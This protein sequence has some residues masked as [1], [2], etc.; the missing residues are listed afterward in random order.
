MVEVRGSLVGLSQNQSYIVRVRSINGLGVKSS[1]S[2]SL[3]VTTGS[4]SGGG[5]GDPDP[6]PDEIPNPVSNLIVT[7]GVNT[8]LVTWANPEQN[9]KYWRVFVTDSDHSGSGPI[10]TTSASLDEYGNPIAQTNGYNFFGITKDS[11]QTISAAC[12]ET[13]GGTWG[14]IKPNTKYWVGALPISPAGIPAN[15]V[16]WASVTT[17]T[18]DN[19]FFSA[20]TISADILRASTLSADLTIAGKFTTQSG[21]SGAYVQMS[22]D[23]LLARYGSPSDTVI[24]DSSKIFEINTDSGTALFKG[25]IQGSTIDIVPND[26]VP[27]ESFH[28]DNLGRLYVGDATYAA[29]PFQVNNN[30][31]LKIQGGGTMTLGAVDGD[32]EFMRISQV[33][34]SGISYSSLGFHRGSTGNKRA[35]LTYNYQ[36]D[37]KHVIRFGSESSGTLDEM[38]LGLNVGKNVDSGRSFLRL[39]RVTDGSLPAGVEDHSVIMYAD[40]IVALAIQGQS[41]GTD[42]RFPTGNGLPG[43]NTGSPDMLPVY[44]EAAT[45]KLYRYT[46]TIRNKFH[47]VDLD[48]EVNTIEKLRGIR[49]V[50]FTYKESGVREYGFI[51]EEMDSLDRKLTVYDKDGEPGGVKYLSVLSLLVAAVQQIDDR[52]SLIERE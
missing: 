39:K 46:S 4:I 33:V 51:A 19:S 23:G 10:D 27:T 6:D 8:I 45:G 14:P 49:P 26:T 47:V 28:V 20:G 31:S 41:G 16:I 36:T 17:G 21:S 32:N 43:T 44:M 5:G 34:S 15:A 13:T 48:S 3:V 12:H 7:A 24:L 1:W 42:I 2:D 18:L 25:A 30:G 38:F 50:A 11:V 35:A 9:L 40:N 52:L 22:P 29:A 37:S